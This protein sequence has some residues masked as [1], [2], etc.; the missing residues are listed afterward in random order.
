MRVLSFL[1]LCLVFSCQPSQPKP[2]YP[3]SLKEEVVDVYFR[4]TIQ[5]PYRWLENDT[6]KATEDWVKRQNEFTRSYLDKLPKKEEIKERLTKLWNYPKRSAP[7]K[8]GD[9]FIYAKNDGIQNQYVYYFKRSK[10]GEEELLMDPNTLSEDG[11]TTVGGFK[12]S[13]DN[14]YATYRIQKSGSDWSEIAVLDMETLKPIDDLV[15]WVKFSGASWYNDGFFYSAYGKPKEGSAFSA[16]NEYQKVYYHK[17]GTAQEEDKLIYE[18]KEH[19]KRGH[20][21]W[22]TEDKEYLILGGSEGTSGSIVSFSKIGSGL[23][24]IGFTPLDTS[25]KTDERIID[26]IDGR[27]LMMTNHKAENYRLVWVDPKSAAFSQWQDCIPEKDYVLEGV[28]RAGDHIICKYLKDVETKLEVYDRTGQYLYDVELPGPGIASNMSGDIDQDYAYFSF[29]SYV[30]PGTAYEYDFNTRSY[31]VN[32]SPEVEFDPNE[33]ESKKVFYQSK[34]GTSIPMFITYKKGIELD[35]SNPTFLYG[36]GGFQ[37]SVRPHFHV[38][39]VAFMEQGGIYAVANLRGGLE[40]GEAWHKSGMLLNKQNVFDDFISAAE[41]L[42]SEGYTSHEKLAI[43][44]RS[45]GG[46]LVGATMTQRP[47]LAAVA[48][49]AVGVLDML[50]YHKFTIGWAWAVEYGDSED[51]INYKNLRAY[52]PLHNVREVESPVTMVLT[53]DHDDRVVPAHSFKFAATLQEKQK[54]S[55]PV[56]IRIDKKAGHGAG[57]PTGKQI[58]EWSDIWAFVLHYLGEK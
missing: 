6:S 45:N 18:D 36:Y 20:Y 50:R 22:V 15:K 8:S 27:F 49:P 39:N 4:D 24:G 57:K 13:E 52:S 55:N 56:L 1:C 26:H 16:S 12:V 32:F 51:S 30:Q 28:S 29:T 31:K 41:Y 37:I 3:E 38:R 2:N 19:A 9:F 46:L 44:G 14:K 33:F 21:A 48:L 58:D 7:Y 47:D 53:A 35:G 25:F 5:D 54:G 17:I 10:D 42:M 43:H 40:Y 23:D 11:T 34:D